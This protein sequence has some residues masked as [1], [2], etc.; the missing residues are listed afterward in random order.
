ML[1]LWQLSGFI[2][3]RRSLHLP[4]EPLAAADTYDVR[5]Y[6]ELPVAQVETFGRF[7]HA[8]DEAYAILRAYR[9]GHNLRQPV[10]IV[11]IRGRTQEASE[12][13]SRSW[14][15]IVEP[16][17]GSLV[18]SMVLPEG[19]SVATAPRPKDPRVRIDVFERQR[20]AVRDIPATR[21]EHTFV[22]EG[23]ALLRDLA[24]SSLLILSQPRYVI[25]GPTWVFAP[26]RHSEVHVRVR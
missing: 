2:G 21:E 22:A 8:L 25:Y 1:V 3:Y 26:L 13:V 17:S 23:V 12:V 7:E 20:I 16:A 9:D 6:P 5:H 15:L 24:S 11:T 18:V 4:F 14:P 10:E 19:M